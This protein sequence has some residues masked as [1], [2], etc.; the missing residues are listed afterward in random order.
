MFN[1]L[2]DETVEK[3]N[4]LDKKVNNDD[5]IYRYKENIADAK[6]DKFNDTL[7]KIRN[8]EISLVDV[9]NNQEKLTS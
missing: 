1:E 9:K 3:I 4:N 5:L 6:F 7:S 2:V 8:G